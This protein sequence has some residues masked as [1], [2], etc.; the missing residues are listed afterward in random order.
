MVDSRIPARGLRLAA[1]LLPLLLTAGCYQP[2]ALQDPYF[3]LAYPQVAAHGEEVA[4]TVRYHRAWQAAQQSCSG[5]DRRG[6]DPA[7]G[8][9]H[10][11]PARPCAGAARPSTPAHG[12]VANAY[13]RWAEDRMRALP[14]SAQTASSI[15]GGS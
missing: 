8:A 2:L 6:P 14:G 15:G 13:K 9:G 10:A 3:G 12:G 1:A 11:K 4:R 7:T 5:E